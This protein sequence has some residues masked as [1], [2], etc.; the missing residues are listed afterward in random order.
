MARKFVAANPDKI[1][2][3]SLGYQASACTISLWYN[4]TTTPGASFPNRFSGVTRSQSGAGLTN[5]GIDW[6]STTI[7]FFYTTASNVFVAFSG[8][9]TPDTGVWHNIVFVSDFTTGGSVCYLD[10]VA[11]SM[12]TS[13]TPGTP[14]NSSGGPNLIGINGN[15][16]GDPTNA[17]LADV[18]V[19]NALLTASEAKALAQGARPNRIRPGTIA[20]WWPL[21][22]LSSPEQ[23]YSGNVSNGTVTGTTLASGPPTMPI[24]TP[25]YPRFELFTGGGGGGGGGSPMLGRIGV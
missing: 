10:G 18:V 22:G 2:V 1:T 23:D 14:S 6:N 15:G 9:Y 7:D 20:G 11:L 17:I 8:A 12:S 5:Y 4:N 21:D 24:T 19:W 13:G 16:T 25:R 3:G